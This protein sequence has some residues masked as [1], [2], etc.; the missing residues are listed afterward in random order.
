MCPLCESANVSRS[1]HKRVKDYLMALV[2]M[3]AYRCHQCRARFYLPANL[4][5]VVYRDR[6]WL[7][8]VEGKRPT[9][10]KAS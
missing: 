8:A 3:K 5:N 6:A 2:R 9:R 1:Q 4:E 7:H 10:S